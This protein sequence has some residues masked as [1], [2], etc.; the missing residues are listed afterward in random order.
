M[1]NAC[2]NALL[3][4]KLT[5]G[6]HA[7]LSL[8]RYLRTHKELDPN[9]SSGKETPEVALLKAVSGYEPSEPYKMA[10]DEWK[11]RANSSGWLTL[12]AVTAGPL[13]IGLGNE[14]SLEVGLSIHH[15]YGMPVIAGS[16]IKGLCRATCRK[17]GFK[18]ESPE[19]L[20]LFGAQNSAGCAVFYDAWY[21]PNTKGGKPFHR[22]VITVHHPKYYGERGQDVWPT[23]FDDPN[24]VPFL[25][26]RPGAQFFFAVQCP[27]P[28]WHDFV[29]SMLQY[30]LTEVGLGAKTN[31]GYGRFAFGQ[32]AT[33]IEQRVASA[34]ASASRPMAHSQS[35][36]T[37]CTD[38][39]PQSR[40]PSALPQHLADRV[41]DTESRP[42]APPPAQAPQ[43]AKPVGKSGTK[44][45]WVTVIK[46]EGSL[47][48]VRLEGTQIDVRC[49][50]V[51]GK[52]Q[53]PGDWDGQR[54]KAT[55]TYENG[56][57]ISARWKSWR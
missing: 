53:R 28:E 9:W 25:V 13:A 10:F 23:D 37:V 29:Q 17:A 27:N 36:S 39:A 4:L 41:Q 8:Y 34:L 3:S 43:P 54:I 14:S 12:E 24:P 40:A 42:S 32:E 19:M 2:R 30:T 21:D 48:L 47:C 35:H 55:V 45:E 6:S 5:N 22:D 57:P 52:Y 26:V 16:A 44:V 50:G 46:D 38:R 15:I 51:P 11:K 1:S 18:D 33:R 56:K 20:A 49:K 7:G 31:A